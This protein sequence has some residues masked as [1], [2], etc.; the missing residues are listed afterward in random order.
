M[1]LIDTHAHLSF[2]GLVENVK[3]VVNRA[4]DAGVKK[5]I[6]IA[7]EAHEFKKVLA[8]AEIY[9]N[10]YAGMGIHP[11]HASEVTEA[12]LENLTSLMTN[13]KV[14]ALGETGLDFHY[15]F[16]K[17]DAQKD[18][19]RKHLQIAAK[20]K[21]PVVVHS[22]NAFDETLEILDEFT[23]KLDKVVFHCYSG[24]AEQTELLL[25]KGYYISFTGIVTF[26]NAESA[27]IAATIVPT[28]KMMLETDCPFMS[29]VPMRN[30]K[31]NEPAL[32]VHTARFIAELK[33]MD[34]DKFC[35]E[36]TETSCEFFGI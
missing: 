26:K 31:I 22:R 32:M 10:V 13:P 11:H 30:Q 8:I 23:G 29:P 35:E 25:S 28:D 14:V 27:K 21:K 4:K 33:G 34:F 2:E 7:T 1:N 24:T 19:F 20:T 36:V 17:Q 12:D 6:T 15:N 3:D 16:S 18:I 5:I 9:E